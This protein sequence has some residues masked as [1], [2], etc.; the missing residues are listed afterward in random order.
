MVMGKGRG[1]KAITRITALVFT[2]AMTLVLASCAGDAGS[3]AS[4][5][6]ES[7]SANYSAASAATSDGGAVA[8]ESSEAT[9]E[10]AGKPWVTS[11][12]QGNLPSEQPEAKDDLYTHYSYEYLSTHQGQPSSAILDHATELQTTNLAVI[13]DNSKSSHDLDQLR[14]FFNQAADAEALKE[15]GLADLQPYLDRIDAVSSIDEMN[16]LLSADDF[17]F[18]PFILAYITLSDTRDVNIVSVSPNL[19]LVDTVTVGGA[20]YQ[21]TDDPQLQKSMEVAVKNSGSMAMLDLMATGMDRDAVNELFPII[22]DF[23]KAH[24]KFVDYNGKYSEEDFGAMAEVA[25][26]GQLSLEELCA[27]CPNF[28]M[29]ATL[30]NQGKGAS[31]RYCASP[32]WLKAF[33]SVWTQENLEAIKLVAKIKVLGETRPYRDPS[34][35]NKLYEDAGQPVP[36]AESFAYTACDQQDT[37]AIVLA[38]TYVD[39]ALGANAKTRLTTLSQQLLD[40]YKNLVDNTPWMGEESQ[41]HVI[42]KLDNMT[43][44]VLEP[45][46]GYYDFAGVE[47]TPT[48][49]GGTLIGNYLK[50]R[51][52]RLDQESKMVGKPAVA[53]CTWFYMK[54]TITNAFYDPTSNSINIAPGFVTSLIYTEDMSDLDL[55]SGAGFT[56]GHEISHGFDYQGAQFDAYGA[57]NPLFA[58]ADVDAFVLKSSTLALFYN[59]LEI[60]PGSMVNGENVITEATADLCGM[61]AILDL[62]GKT[63]GVDYDKFFANISNMWA[64]VVPES[65]LPNL[66]LDP[67]PMHNLRVN[68]NAQMFDPIYDALGVAEG[69]TMY[70]APESRI[71]I[72]G[73]KA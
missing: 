10:L 4:A 12:L 65:S 50:L 58:D 60:A 61:H 43:L 62:A 16:A 39:E 33:N 25:K 73:P 46:G 49:K 53:A 68:V 38:K 18:S 66:A 44:N 64:Q 23:E 47:L 69:D 8:S 31:P 70:L 41:K 54:P 59:G 15:R 6:A 19:A 13:K 51:K 14:I 72:W 7:G 20:Y 24:G 26:K 57:P 36:D 37:F 40:T 63:E 29:K 45:T 42:E 30:D 35:V 32:E 71:N 1:M 3:S 34:V 27:A 67:H 55:L 17:P 2:L 9:G 52:Y 11:I 28:P 21:D 5:S 56:I 48:D 22:L